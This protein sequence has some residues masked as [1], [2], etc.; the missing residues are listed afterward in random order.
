MEMTSIKWIAGL[1][2]IFML[3]SL[4]SSQPKR[5]AKGNWGGDH[6]NVTVDDDSASIEYDCA[7]GTIKGPLATD[8]NGSF[9]LEG[10]HAAERGGPTRRDDS[11]SGRPAIYTGSIKGE[12]MTLTVKSAEGDET[13]GTF[14][15]THG[16]AGKIFKCR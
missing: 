1:A 8:G 9:K 7:H 14:T 5:I 3:T 4:N 11:N 2:V 13:I 16:K 10:T 12:V 15:L 6:I